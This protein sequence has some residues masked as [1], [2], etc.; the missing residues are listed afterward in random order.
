MP[1]TTV[2]IIHGTAELRPGTNFYFL[3]ST[4]THGDT[5][6][7]GPYVFVEWKSFGR[8]ARVWDGPEAIDIS[9]VPGDQLADECYDDVVELVPT[10]N[11]TAPESKNCGCQ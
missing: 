9:F 6:T 8:R 1:S 5:A 4:C 11:Y 3:V 7:Y 10:E 2:D